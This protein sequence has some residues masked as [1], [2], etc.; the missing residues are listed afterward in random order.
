[1]ILKGGISTTVVIKDL[2]GPVSK[3]SDLIR[4]A[5]S[6]MLAGGPFQ[7]TRFHD[8]MVD[9]NTRG[10]LINN[11]SQK[12][13]QRCKEAEEIF[14]KSVHPNN[15]YNSN[16]FVKYSRYYMIELHDMIFKIL[17][18]MINCMTEKA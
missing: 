5:L 9:R 2:S 3:Q 17:H 11:A 12:P 6:M 10:T 8:S 18:D 13:V 14:P 4:P 15:Q 1:M 16:E 7:A